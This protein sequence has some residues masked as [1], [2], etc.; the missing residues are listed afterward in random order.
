MHSQPQYRIR[1]QLKR[2]FLKG[3]LFKD[4][5]QSLG[6]TKDA[7]LEDVSGLRNMIGSGINNAKEGIMGSSAM[8]FLRGLPTPGNLLM[9][10]ASGRNPLNP[11][12][13]NYNRVAL[14]SQI[15]TMKDKGMYGIQIQLLV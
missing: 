11:K 14:Q 4:A 5:K 9:S 6:Q 15:D 10:I 1:D 13:A 8:D 2:D 7:F 12:S 3:G